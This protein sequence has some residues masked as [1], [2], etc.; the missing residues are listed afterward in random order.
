MER[1]KSVK[2]ELELR[3]GRGL[4]P[5]AAAVAAVVTALTLAPSAQAAFPGRNGV[6]AAGFGFG[7][8]GS[9]IGTMEPDGS[10]FQ[11]I[12][13]TACVDEAP[14]YQSPE[15][16]ADGSRLLVSNLANAPIVLT[17]DGGT[18]TP[19]PLV[20]T[21]HFGTD[22]PSVSPDGTRVAYTRTVPTPRGARTE[23][24]IAKLDGTGDRRLRDGTV[25]R[26]SPDGRTI[27]YVAPV[28]TRRGKPAGGGTW[29]MRATTGKRI[30]RVAPTA[31]T[32]DWSPDGSRIVY[33][34]AECCVDVNTD[35][36]VA[37]ADG[38]GTRRLT[39]TRKRREYGAVFS[40]DGRRVAY[41]RSKRLGEEEIQFSIF[42]VS[43]RGGKSR[44][45]YKSQVMNR[46]EVSGAG[47]VISWQPLAD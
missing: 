37:R 13:P 35:L 16:F 21:P 5:L 15:W 23:I 1:V 39:G 34:P 45:I 6:L 2:P 38:R 46:Q 9:M 3:R 24:W 22:K 7:C 25:P 31:A 26:W 11:L 27:A 43:A 10:D 8:D 29:L 20:T 42:T 47:P 4:R 32:L 19:V 17:A 33:S 41:V 14:F 40:P 36:Y 30:R 18:A 12:T 44:R 28:V